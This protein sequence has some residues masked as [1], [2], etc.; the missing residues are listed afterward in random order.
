MKRKRVK[1]QKLQIPKSQLNINNDQR[2]EAG[3]FC[4]IFKQVK[5]P[6]EDGI[7]KAVKMLGCVLAD[8][9]MF[10]NVKNVLRVAPT[11]LSCI[12]CLSVT[13]I[14]LLAFIYKI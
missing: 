13:L 9:K 4:L 6:S 1:C 10:E 5:C 12:S 8:L 11:L 14:V 7:N 2:D 3:M